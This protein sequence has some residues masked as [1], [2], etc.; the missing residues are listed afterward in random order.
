M[1]IEAYVPVD[2]LFRKEFSFSSDYAVLKIDEKVSEYN[3]AMSSIL[4]ALVCASKP[5]QS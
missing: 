2:F 1:S 3:T 5:I 4:S